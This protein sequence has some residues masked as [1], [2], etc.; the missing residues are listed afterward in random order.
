MSNLLTKIGNAIKTE[1]ETDLQFVLHFLGTPVGASISEEVANLV[2]SVLLSNE[3]ESDRTKIANYV[4]SVSNGIYTLCDGNLPLVPAFEEYLKS[5]TDGSD[6]LHA[7]VEILTK[8]YS[9]IYSALENNGDTSKAIAFF[10]AVA[11]GVE[12]AAAE[13]ATETNPKS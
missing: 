7:V 2:T 5:F 9:S 8:E 4:Y 1:S 12:T 6:I 13:Y 10:E 3:S 11:Q